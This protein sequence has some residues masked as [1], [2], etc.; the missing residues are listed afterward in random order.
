MFSDRAP[1]S[2]IPSKNI[3]KQPGAATRGVD[4]LA[5]AAPAR[6]A[7]APGQ[8]GAE[9]PPGLDTPKLSGVDKDLAERKKQADAATAAKIK[10]DEERVAK[11]KADNCERARTNKTLMESGVRVSQNNAQGE[12]VVLDDAARAAEIKRSQMVIDVSC[13]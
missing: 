1:P 12:R 10:A 13:K 9:T 8:T 2:D 7:S 5:N 11:A 3:L 6:A 4:A